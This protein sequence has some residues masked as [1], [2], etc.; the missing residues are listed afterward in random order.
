[1]VAEKIRKTF[2]D[3]NRMWMTGTMAGSIVTFLVIL[4]TCYVC[5]P[6]VSALTCFDCSSL[7]ES[8]CS[9]PL[10]G[11]TEIVACDEECYVEVTSSNITRGCGTCN[12]N[13]DCCPT[14]LCNNERS[15]STPP[16]AGAGTQC[17]DCTYRESNGVKYGH[18]SCTWEE[19]DQLHP[20]VKTK[21]C[22]TGCLVSEI[23]AEDDQG[24]EYILTRRCAEEGSCADTCMTQPG[25]R[26]CN[27]CCNETLCNGRRIGL[28]EVTEPGNQC[29][30]CTYSATTA[31]YIGSP[32]CYKPFNASG[33]GVRKEA[34]TGECRLTVIRNAQTVAVQRSCY[35]GCLPSHQENDDS[36]NSVYCCTGSL[37]NSAI[38]L[39]KNVWVVP[40]ILTI[41]INLSILM[42]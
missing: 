25:Y 37:C 2:E 3:I 20:L 32:G 4:T 27:S 23:T 34:C 35:P 24:R 10:H 41:V 40:C 14:D 28:V 21:M 36:E 8:E 39:S 18:S 9:R 29:Y 26:S 16:I 30:S 7:H 22:S 1:M 6:S 12:D 33:E 42:F 13:R 31:G 38:S 5:F 15:S 11:S 17:Y 19:F